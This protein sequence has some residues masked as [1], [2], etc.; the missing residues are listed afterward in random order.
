M[1]SAPSP[2]VRA[3]EILEIPQNLGLLRADTL[4]GV[5]R[6]DF[7]GKWTHV[8]TR[9]MQADASADTILHHLRK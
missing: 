3:L 6:E 4:D 2:E 1:G 9:E 5:N 8:C 7:A